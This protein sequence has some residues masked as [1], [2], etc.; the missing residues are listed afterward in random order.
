[1]LD[2]GQF[3][4]D[5]RQ[6]EVR[7]LVRDTI[8]LFAPVAGEKRIRL[9]AQVATAPLYAWCDR[10]RILQVLSNLVGNAIKF[11]P[12]GGSLT[13][14]VEASGT[15]ALFCVVDTGPGI[16]P[17]ELKKV[18]GRYWRGR[19]QARR[20]STGTGLGLFI[21]KSIVDTH[22]GEIWAQ[23]TLGRG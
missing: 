19:A 7:A 12:A 11:T 14:R 2:E 16:A 13:L 15:M 18:F 10:D 22:A 20:S 3:A 21:A 9:D 5:R 23:S 4:L 17:A 6:H 8:E 1:R